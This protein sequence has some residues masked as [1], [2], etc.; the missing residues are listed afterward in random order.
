MV[1]TF[2]FRNQSFPYNYF[3]DK[4]RR[5]FPTNIFFTIYQVGDIC[6]IYIKQINANN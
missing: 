4:C 5:N 3:V 2:I 6:F 1:I